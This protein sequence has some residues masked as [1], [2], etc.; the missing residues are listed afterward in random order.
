MLTEGNPKCANSATSANHNDN[1]SKN[2]GFVCCVHR[3]SP[4][5][6]SSESMHGIVYR[7]MRAHNLEPT[8]CDRASK[9]TGSS[10]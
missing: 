10:G 1:W 5:C 3:S 6:S 2:Y 8:E 4:S 9:N 7:S